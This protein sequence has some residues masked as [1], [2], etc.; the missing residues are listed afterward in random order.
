MYLSHNGVYSER[1][2]EMIKGHKWY[3]GAWSQTYIWSQLWSQ[4]YIS[5]YVVDLRIN[6]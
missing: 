4:T 5:G 2:Y 3:L 1:M 6:K